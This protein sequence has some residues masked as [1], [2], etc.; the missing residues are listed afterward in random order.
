MEATIPVVHVGKKRE[1]T[2]NNWRSSHTSKWQ[3]KLL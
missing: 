3:K 2:I 1:V